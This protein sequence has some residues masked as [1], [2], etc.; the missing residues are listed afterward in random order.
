MTNVKQVY[1]NIIKINSIRQLVGH[2]STNKAI[3]FSALVLL[4]TGG[5]VPAEDALAQGSLPES[6]SS[7]HWLEEKAEIHTVWFFSDKVKLQRLAEHTISRRRSLPPEFSVSENSLANMLDWDFA[8]KGHLLEQGNGTVLGYRKTTR[9]NGP[10]FFKFYS[11]EQFTMYFEE[12]VPEYIELNNTSSSRILIFWSSWGHQQHSCFAYPTSGKITMRRLTVPPELVEWPRDIIPLGEEKR[13]QTIEAELDLRFEK[14]VDENVV[15]SNGLRTPR[16][17]A[18][19]ING[20]RQFYWRP[21]TDF[22]WDK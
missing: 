19:E 22:S 10:M 20:Y 16:C 17:P 7:S 4:V 3:L 1:C 6:G 8:R 2:I 18:F 13:F 15:L 14:I 5:A 9:T 12:E 21:L 11:V